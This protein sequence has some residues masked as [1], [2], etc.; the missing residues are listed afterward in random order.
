VSYNAAG[1][2]A[3]LPTMLFTKSSPGFASRLV[4]GVGRM[5]E[6]ESIFY[7]QVRPTLEINSPRGYYAVCD[8]RT[9]YSMI[10]LE[11]VSKTRGATFG[12]ALQAVT[13][14][15]AEDMVSQ[16]AIYHG[17][18]WNSPAFSAELLAVRTA[19]TV[20][21]WL[22]PVAGFRRR[23]LA[24]LKKSATVVPAALADAGEEIWAAF[25][26]SLAL[27]RH[28]PQTLLHEDVHPGNWYRDGDGRM[29]LYDWQALA[30]GHWA[31]DYSYALVAALRVEDRR[32]WERDLLELYIG[33]LGARGGA[34]LNFDQA[35][36]G[37]RLQPL[38][39]L[40]YWLFTIGRSRFEPELQKDEYSLAIIERL[41]AM[42]D[43][44]DTLDAV[45]AA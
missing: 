8:P 28:A 42:I 31:Q 25:M 11:D 15:E 18:Y 39:G 10:V 14:A 7:R 27:Q 19:E 1:V 23:T 38:H 43:D 9:F 44:H 2:Q 5:G 16:L 3:Q 4:L 29:G 17:A 35:W 45:A 26:K 13:R 24:G 22:N 12:N 32:A 37:Y 30:R 40:A 6:G 34:R 21:R 33:E 20:Q 36:Q 41:A